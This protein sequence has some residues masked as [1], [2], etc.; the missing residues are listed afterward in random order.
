MSVASRAPIVQIIT[1][2]CAKN[3]VDSDKMRAALRAAGFCV[4]DD[5]SQRRS[6]S[7]AHERPGGSPMAGQVAVPVDPDVVIVNTCSFITEAT[8]ESIDMI[9]S[10][11]DVATESDVLPK[12]VVAGCMPARYGVD[13]EVEFP[14]VAAFVPVKEEPA[15]VDIVS[16]LTGYDAGGAFEEGSSERTMQAPYAYVK[17]SDG[18]DRRCAF[19]TIPFVRGPYESRTA[20]EVIGEV[21]DLVALGVREIILIGQDTGI[22]GSDFRDP[23][24]SAPLGEPTLACLLDHLASE[25]PDTWFRVMYLQ[26]ERVDDAL[27]LAMRSHDNVCEYLDIPLQHCNAKVVREM[28]RH[29]DAASYAGLVAHIR[30]V[31]PNAAVRTTL[32]TG[33]P[34]ETEEEFEELLSFVEETPFDYAGVFEYSREDGTEAGERDDQVPEETGLERAQLIRDAADVVGFARAGKHVGQTCDVLVCGL[35]DDCEETE[36]VPGRVWGR[37]M[38]QAPDVDGVVYVEASGCNVGDVLR[39]RIT[40][41]E[42]YDLEGCIAVG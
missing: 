10:V 13:L 22:W 16:R 20:A 25:F 2:G 39:V 7:E 35:D 37:T 5:A 29:G 19:C 1:M 28:N 11:A 23:A 30:E 21:G 42:G 31:L 34:G 12:I 27:L 36:S 17:I 8:Q 33:F 14:E 32:I 24:S 6:V 3:E 41:A 9:L 18:C 26:P 40:G 15:I 4:D 38:F